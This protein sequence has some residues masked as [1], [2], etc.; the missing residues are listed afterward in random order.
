MLI[1][2]STA[3]AASP[4]AKVTKVGTFSSPVQVVQ[5]PGQSTRLWVV[6]KRGQISVLSNG[7]V[8]SAVA[9]DIGGQVAF[10]SEQGLLGLAFAPD[11]ATSHR[12]Y[13]TYTDKA[14]QLVLAEYQGTYTTLNPETKRVVM[15][16]PKPQDDHN[17]G[18]IRFGADGYLYLG[19]GDGGGPGDRHG[20]IG[21]AQDLNSLLGKILRIDPRAS[22]SAAYSVPTSNPF[23]GLAGKKSEVWAYGLR[24]PWRWSFAPDGAMWIGDVG[25]DTFEE[26]D[27]VTTPGA[28][29]GWRIM[30]GNRIREG[31]VT[32]QT[33]TPPLVAYPHGS[34]TGCAVIGGVVVRDAKLTKLS[35]KYLYGDFCNP[36][37]QWISYANGA[38]KGKGST[39]IKFSSMV[40]SIDED[41]TGRVYVTLLT[42]AVYRLSA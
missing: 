6:R 28:N 27:R 23:Y 2:A 30:E 35:G 31:D 41:L 42:G 32:I 14:N 21:N 25:Q 39:S 17:G 12:A 22:G 9:L 4:M 20:T 24:N 10:G 1:F 33:L 3:S 29:L 37:L 16:I 36:T 19:T 38:V 7:K 34:A 18:T 13:V 8:Q 11:F 40:V 26:I 5:P 15:T